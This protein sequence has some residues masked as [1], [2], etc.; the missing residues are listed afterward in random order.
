MA[1][2]SIHRIKKP[3]DDVYAHPQGQFVELRAV[4][5]HVEVFHAVA[6]VGTIRIKQDHALVEKHA[7]ALRRVA[8]VLVDLGQ[9]RKGVFAFVNG[10]VA[11]DRG[12]RIFREH[13]GDFPT[14]GLVHAVA[15]VGPQK[16]AADQVF[17]EPQALLG[18][19]MHVAV[20]R[21]INKGETE[22][23]VGSDVDDNQ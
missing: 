21:H 15:V 14:K 10:M 5:V 7:E 3:Y 8:V 2:L 11:L 6:D 13:R 22:Q 16:P 23:A 4:V 20:A 19:K 12:Q 1:V 18:G 17:S 9:A